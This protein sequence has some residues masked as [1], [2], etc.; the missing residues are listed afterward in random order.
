[1][2]ASAARSALDLLFDLLT[3]PFGGLSPIVGLVFV[4]LLSGIWMIL[5]FKKVS[6]QRSIQ[7][8]RRRMGAQAL[9]MLLFLSSPR[10]VLT[11]AGGLLWS[12]FRYLAMILLPLLVI[13]LP[14]GLTYGQLEARYSHHYLSPSDTLTATLSYAD[15]LPNHDDAIASYNGLLPVPPVV[16]IDSLRQLSLRLSATG[17]IVRSLEVGGNSLPVGRAALRSGAIVYSGAEK[18]SI[19]SL[20]RPGSALISGTGSEAALVSLRLELPSTDYRVLWSGW[21]WLAVF[22]VFSTLSAVAGAIVFKVKV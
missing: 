19:G 1:M 17:G 12:N 2:I 6:P 18:A 22:L 4:S 5:V 13:A 10:Q 3:W 16:S 20:F 21:S 14:F 11:L 8:L 7:R 15:E 9:G